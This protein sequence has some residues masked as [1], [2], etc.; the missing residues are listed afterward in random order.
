MK[1]P[2]FSFITNETNQTKN[3]SRSLFDL[4]NLGHDIFDFSFISNYYNLPENFTFSLDLKEW[5]ET[6]IE[7]FVNFSDPLAV[8]RG[9]IHDKF[10]VRIK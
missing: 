7:L 5:N 3:S 8:S 6:K 2:D 4:K 9:G 1:I 10:L